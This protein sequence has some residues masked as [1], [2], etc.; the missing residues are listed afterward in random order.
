VA[1]SPLLALIA[2][3]RPRAE[4]LA[5]LTSELRLQ[6]LASDCDVVV[7]ADPADVFGRRALSAAAAGA[8]VVTVAGGAAAAVLQDLTPTAD[9]HDV[10]SLRRALDAAHERAAERAQRSARVAELCSPPAVAR[11]I[12]EL[13]DAGSNR[14]AA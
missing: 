4:V 1:S 8:A 7:D 6:V 5:P 11:R 3:R 12:A 10:A 13:A 14:A 9:P 2:E